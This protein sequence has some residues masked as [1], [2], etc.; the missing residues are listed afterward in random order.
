[1]HI[2]HEEPE[3]KADRFEVVVYWPTERYTACIYRDRVELVGSASARFRSEFECW[4]VD[5][6]VRIDQLQSALRR[7]PV[8]A[9][10]IRFE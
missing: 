6:W 4:K 9:P 2:K 5:E 7:A 8:G 1:M 10:S 3:R